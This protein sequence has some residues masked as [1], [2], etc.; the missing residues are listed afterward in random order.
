[1]DFE[2]ESIRAQSKIEKP[3]YMNVNC[4]EALGLNLKGRAL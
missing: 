4:H 1:M 3:G 2:F